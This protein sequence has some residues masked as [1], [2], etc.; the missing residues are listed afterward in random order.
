[1]PSLPVLAGNALDP[2]TRT[3]FTRTYNQQYKG[4]RER[5]AMVMDTVPSDKLTEVYAYPK[6]APYAARWPRGQERKRKGFEFVKYY[7]TNHEWSVGTRWH[8]N[9][10][11]DDQTRSLVSRARDVASRAANIDE[12]VF[13]QILQGTTDTDLLPAVPTAP[14]GV[15]LFSASSRFGYSS[16]NLLTGTGVALGSTVLADFWAQRVAFRSYQD[17]EGQPLLDEQAIDD[18]VYVIFYNATLDLVFRQA[19]VQSRPAQ[20]LQNVAASENVALATPTNITIESGVKVR[21]VPTQRI[22]DN[23]WYT[24]LSHDSIPVK[25]IFTQSRWPLTERVET[26]DN[27]DRARDTGF[28]GFD[29][30]WRSG[31]SVNLP[32]MAIETTN[33]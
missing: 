32:Y 24:I 3:E 30:D 29:F 9:D 7:V 23:K 22:T 1:M 12:R 8:K 13:F 27:S 17:S 15:A 16:G 26:M 31:Y 19:F 4:M 14:D 33:S 10:E 21:L 5:L 6:T 18:G 20:R 28:I 11:Q 2:G 25:P